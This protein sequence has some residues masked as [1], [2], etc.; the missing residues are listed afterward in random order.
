MDNLQVQ[1]EFWS[2]F[3]WAAYEENSVPDKAVLPYITYE[4][5]DTNYRDGRRQIMV[6]LWHRTNVWGA[7]IAKEK[8][9]AG[10]IGT[11]IYIPCEGGAVYFDRGTPWAQ[12][13][14]D[15]ADDSIRRIVLAVEMESII[16]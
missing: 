8:E 7:L 9:I 5:P 6:S 16:Q 12:R 1:N 15:A 10:A 3:G 2:G 11:G 14:R 4:A 13:M